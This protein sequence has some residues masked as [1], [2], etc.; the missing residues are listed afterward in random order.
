[1]PTAR[2]ICD[3][4]FPPHGREVDFYTMVKLI[5]THEK[6]FPAQVGIFLYLGI[7]KFFNVWYCIHNKSNKGDYKNV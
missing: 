2:I 3:K 7:D 5:V 6:F 1:M 4:I